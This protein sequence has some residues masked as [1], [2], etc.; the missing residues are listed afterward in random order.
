[1]KVSSHLYIDCAGGN[2]GCVHVLFNERDGTTMG[3]EF[4]YFD[5]RSLLSGIH[6]ATV[7]FLHGLAKG[8]RDVDQ[9]V[10]GGRR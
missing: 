8:G 6:D 9:S 3:A 5:D 4:V 7:L 1:M 10:R 2:L